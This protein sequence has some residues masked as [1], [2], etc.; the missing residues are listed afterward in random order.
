MITQKLGKFKI[1]GYLGG[2][3]FGDVYLAHDTLLDSK[4]ALKIARSHINDFSLFLNEVKILFS[5]E[6]PNILRY[7]SAESI[8]GKLVLVTEYIEG[9]TLR[10]FIEKNCPTNHET[11]NKIMLSIADAVDYA[12]S[13]DLIHRDLKP[14]NIMLDP[15]GNIKIMDFGLAKFVEKDLTQSM[16]GT[17]TYMSPE[18]WNGKITTSTDQWSLAVIGLEMLNGSNPF[19]ANN[20]EDIREKI[21]KP[22]NASDCFLFSAPKAVTESFLK[23]LSPDPELRFAT[24]KD[25]VKRAFKYWYDRKRVAKKSKIKG[26]PSILP[27]IKNPTIQNRKKR[28]LTKEQ[29]QAISCQKK[30]VL[31]L[32]GP[33]T[34]KTQTLIEKAYTLVYWRKVDPVKIFITTFTVKGWQDLEERLQKAL[35]TKAR[36]ICI[37]NFHRLCL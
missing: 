25:F 33:G 10:D 32:G 3:R 18:S 17:P 26:H 23:A 24:C 9:H 34:G 19:F 36:D 20:L 7:F 29:T 6:H 21:M 35:K 28:R 8:E 13:K 30:R 27:N 11:A 16:G 22:L 1:I 2:G 4:V 14:E 37:G 31:I 5:L 15:N 12:N